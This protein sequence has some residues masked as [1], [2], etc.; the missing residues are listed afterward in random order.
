MSKTDNDLASEIERIHQR[1]DVIEREL[2]EVSAMDDRVTKIGAML[3]SQDYVRSIA[4]AVSMLLNPP[5]TPKLAVA[6]VI[7]S[8]WLTDTFND[9]T[10]FQC[11]VTG[12]GEDANVAVYAKQGDTPKQVHLTPEIMELVTNKIFMDEQVTIGKMYAV[13]LLTEGA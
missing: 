5:P 1:L 4:G 3:T 7:I 13:E 8:D 2:S 9:E 6:D 12:V 11:V 10:H